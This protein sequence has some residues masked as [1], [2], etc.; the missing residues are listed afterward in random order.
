MCSSDLFAF[1][2]D[3]AVVD[4]NI[5]R[6]Y[7]RLSGERLTSKAVQAAADAA[8][9]SGE[10]WEWNQCLMDL[11]AVLC[12]PKDPKC[13]EC[14]LATRCSWHGVG[15]DPAIGSAGVSGPQSRFEGSDRQGRGRLIKRLG[16]GAVQQRDVAATMGWPA[17]PD[18]AQRVLATLI[19][20][21]LVT[22]DDDGYRLP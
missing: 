20:D 10:S 3:A 6:V 21:G 19:A 7:A 18:R 16:E 12:R 8:L 2:N 14:P 15:S 22:K 9:P 11:G 4:T 17:Q 5:A 13:E 1:E